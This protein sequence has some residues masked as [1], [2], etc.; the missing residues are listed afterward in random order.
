MKKRNPLAKKKKELF[1]KDIEKKDW[2]IQGYKK[3]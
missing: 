3:P 1:D 2:V